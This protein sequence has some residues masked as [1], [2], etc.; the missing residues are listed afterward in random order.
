MK[1]LTNWLIGI[2]D[3]ARKFYEKAAQRFKDDA[4]L[5]SLLSSI[6]EDERR[7]YESVKGAYEVIKD[8]NVTS[9]LRVDD[10]V[11]KGLEDSFKAAEEKLDK[12]ELTKQML[13]EAIVEIEYSECNDVFLY[14]INTLKAYPGIYSSA[15]EHIKHHTLS[16]EK[17]ISGKPEY[18]HL[19][20][21][22]RA[23]PDFCKNSFLVVDDEKAM[24]SIFSVLLG[25]ENIVESAYNGKEA[26]AKLDAG[27]RFDAII[28][29]I[30]MPEM[31]GI[32]FYNKASE[33]YPGLGRR[34][35]FLTGSFDED[36]IA[37]FKRN[38]LRF[39]MK[40]ASIK[41]IK[42]TLAEIMMTSH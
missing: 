30:D 37:F 20:A 11:R 6:A 8:H 21:K 29:D 10:E 5:Y 15:S 16:I 42:K 7:H 14:I 41:E 4:E 18:Y 22:I 28:S 34:F 3:S 38:K 13:V 33:K 32:E 12:G 17:Y 19:L 1:S 9:A 25:G 24:I 2:E 40:P 35:L 27:K 36:R 23:L 31:N 26:M 39:L